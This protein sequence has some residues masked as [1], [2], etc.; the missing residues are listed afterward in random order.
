MGFVGR[1]MHPKP[2]VRRSEMKKKGFIDNQ[3]NGTYRSNQMA[4]RESS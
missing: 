3:A 2:H 1:S 4:T